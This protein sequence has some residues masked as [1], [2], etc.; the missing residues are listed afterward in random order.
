M[1]APHVCNPYCHEGVHA[2]L[3]YANALYPLSWMRDTY[4]GENVLPRDGG[5]EREIVDVLPAPEVPA[6]D[7]PYRFPWLILYREIGG[8]P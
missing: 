1:S 8:M 3:D 2:E 6:P 5:P 7:A 4:V